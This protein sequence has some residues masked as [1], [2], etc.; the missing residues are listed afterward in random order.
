M[1]VR[2]VIVAEPP[3]TS[4]TRL[5]PFPLIV[6]GAA[7]GPLIVIAPPSASFSGPAVRVIVRAAA[8]TRGSNV[9][10]EVVARAL[11]RLIAWRRPS[12]PGSE[13][14][15]SVVTLTTERP[16]WLWKAPMST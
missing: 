3:S 8:N 9:T 16:A 5:A 7:A 11:A 14:T 10:V 6:S 1:I 2:P 15:P 12:R 4:N 13:P